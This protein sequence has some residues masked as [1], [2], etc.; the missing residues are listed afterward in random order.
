MTDRIYF[1]LHRS[2]SD[3]PDVLN[4]RV[5]GPGR[6]VTLSLGHQ[7]DR[8][9]WDQTLQLCRSRTVHGPDRLPAQRINNDITRVTLALRALPDGT[10]DRSVL[11]RAVNG[12]LSISQDGA[13]SRMSTE[14]A[15][16]TYISEQG[17]VR[18][19]TDG[20]ARS[21]AS[22]AKGL[23]ACGHFTD[24]SLVGEHSLL[25][26]VRWLRGKGLN[27]S[28]VALRLGAAK[29]FLSW[30]KRRDLVKG[31]PWEDFAP[32]FR[33]TL[34][35]VVYLTWEEIM[36]LWHC[37]RRLTKVQRETLDVFLFC[38]FTGLRYS[39]AMA[40]RWDQVKEDC[41]ELVTKKTAKPIRV[42]LN[43]WSIDVLTRHME[44]G[45]ADGRVFRYRRNNSANSSLREIG[46]LCGIDEPVTIV[47]YRGGERVETTTPKYELMSSHC[48]RR[49]FVC[50]ALRLGVPASVVMSWTGHS[51][52]AAMTPYI[53][54]DHGVKAREMHKMD[55]VTQERHNPVS[56]DTEMTL[57]DTW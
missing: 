55:D 53:E 36:G 49:T 33:S 11:R 27:D 47:R 4:V 37:D 31:G 56:G 7:V 51:S 21:Y 18:G 12:A 29:A 17:T 39:D 15:L 57:D 1:F 24:L 20:T 46:G 14:E 19:W 6:S 28:T 25:G 48:A 54:I 16:R 52:Y 35:P 42:N 38:C 22:M 40:L 32:R 41:I 3:A 44:D 43:T 13:P 10:T 9:G 50:N 8:D 5:G 30:C 26:Y 34:R 2:R 45:L 23:L